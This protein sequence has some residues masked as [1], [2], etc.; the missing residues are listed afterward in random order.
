MKRFASF[1]VAGLV[2]AMLSAPAAVLAA[3]VAYRYASVDGIRIFYREAGDRNKPTIVLLHGFP[4][5]SHMFRDLIP[6]LSAHFHLIAPDYPGMGFSDAPPADKFAPTFDSVAG[7]TE[8]FLQQ[9][10]ETKVIVYMQDFGGPVGMRIATD[11]PEWIRGLIVQNT[12]ISDDGWDPARLK[13]VRA[14]AGPATPEKRAAAESRVVIDTAM[15]LYKKGAR[16][17]EQLNPDAWASDAYALSDPEKRRIMTD[18][19]LDIPSN[20]DLYPKWQ[21]YL[22]KNRPETL[23]VWGKGDPVFAVAGAESVKRYVP[24]AEVHI[25]DAGHFA[26]EED[27]PDIARQIIR[28][29]SN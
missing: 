7:V 2:G 18:L 5:S 28:K 11:H 19:Q 9:L 26:L 24:K 20:L 8:K 29:F 12:P 13:A 15:L 3:P 6:L 16:N 21:G 17:P 1:V 27:A 23:V 4:S 22:Q 14:N 25:Y 10:G